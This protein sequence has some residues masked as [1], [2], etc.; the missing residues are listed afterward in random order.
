MPKKCIL[1]LLDGI[2]DR[3][4]K[5]FDNQTPLQAARTP[6]LDK[7]AAGG[8]NG[9]YHA[10]LLGQALPSENAHFHMF[11]YVFM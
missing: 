8:S 6:V 3:S 11:G 5:Q 1:L 9:L 2:G 10:A 7:I 4:Y